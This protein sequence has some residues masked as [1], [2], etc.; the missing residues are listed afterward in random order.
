MNDE[1]NTNDERGST[2]TEP[3]LILH[4]SLLAEDAVAL[5]NDRLESLVAGTDE[6]VQHVAQGKRAV[7]GKG[8]LSCESAPLN[9]SETADSE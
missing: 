8:W 7:K 5:D 1:T 4:T 9:R 3:E 6:K 2:E